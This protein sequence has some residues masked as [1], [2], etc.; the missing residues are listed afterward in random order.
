MINTTFYECRNL[1]GPPPAPFA[2]S[3][4]YDIIFNILSSKQNNTK[5]NKTSICTRYPFTSYHRTR[6]YTKTRSRFDNRHLHFIRYECDDCTKTVLK[7]YDTRLIPGRPG[8]TSGTHWS[9]PRLLLN[10]V[11]RRNNVWRVHSVLM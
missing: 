11:P 7:P 5:T 2:C 9:V 8:G 1:S 4:T 6:P 10:R 3:A